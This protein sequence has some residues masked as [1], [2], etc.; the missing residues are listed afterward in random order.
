MA[1]KNFR[2]MLRTLSQHDSNNPV[3]EYIDNPYQ[4]TMQD[5]W[6]RGLTVIKRRD[7]VLS[8]ATTKDQLLDQY[9]ED[10]GLFGNILEGK[11]IDRLRSKKDTISF[12]ELFDGEDEGESVL[13]YLEDGDASLAYES[14]EGR[15]ELERILESMEPKK[16]RAVVH[17]IGAWIMQEKGYKL[18]N[19]VVQKIRN[20]RKRYNLPLTLS[21]GVRHPRSNHKEDNHDG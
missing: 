14:I 6:L 19:A 10:E 21:M 18:S 11:K 1:S 8:D 13:D 15:D 4:D 7:T 12:T 20:D 9:G 3:T 5:A 2:A 17:F 16:R